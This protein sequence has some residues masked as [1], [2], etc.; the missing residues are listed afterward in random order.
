M[1][2]PPR[3]GAPRP[4]GPRLG[5]PRPGG[6][7]P[8]PRPVAPR[9]GAALLQRAKNMLL[10]PSAEWQVIAGEFTTVGAIYRGYVLP[11]AAIPAVCEIVGRALWGITL[12]TIGTIHVSPMTALRGGIALYIGQLVVVQALALIID[13]LAPTFGGTRNHVQAIKVAAYSS[14]ASWVAGVFALVPGGQWLELLGIYSLYL[15]YA[16]LPPL[17]KAPRDRAAGYA[18]FS[19]ISAVVLYLVMRAITMAFLPRGGG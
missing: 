17:M 1:A 9:R 14:T 6:S 15:L 7:R 12:P 4:G 19:I 2:T 8:A 18:V 16:G 13:A 10:Q 11:L 5:A 3:P